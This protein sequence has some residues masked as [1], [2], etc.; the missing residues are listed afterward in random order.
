MKEAETQ[1]QEAGT[2]AKK[3]FEQR[4]EAYKK[5]VEETNKLVEQAQAPALSAEA[6]SAKG[7][8][9][10]AKIAEV[11]KMEGGIE[12][13]R[14]SREQQLQ[15][16]VT[17]MREMILKEI[18]DAVSER[19]KAN[20]YDL[21]FDKSGPGASGISPVLYSH[22]SAD[23]TA[24]VIAA[25]KKGSAAGRAGS[26]DAGSGY[27]GSDHAGACESDEALGRAGSVS[28]DVAR[29]AFDVRRDAGARSSDL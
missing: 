17:R 19:V 12:E 22:E 24:D 13:F 5:M 4:I 14:T 1:V 6:K 8:E 10:D 2:A 18:A 23:F 25:I 9:R 29:C 16:Q 27:A 15:Q 11:R 3:E 20:N 28:L 26:D 7:K 21:V